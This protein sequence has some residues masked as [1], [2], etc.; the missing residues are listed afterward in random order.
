M[1]RKSYRKQLEHP[2]W[3]LKRL[4]VLKLFGA[5]CMRCGDTETMLHI[6]H[7]S[8]IPGLKPW[9]YDN[10]FYEVLCKNCH[11]DKHFPEPEVKKDLVPGYCTEVLPLIAELFRNYPYCNIFSRI[12]DQLIKRSEQ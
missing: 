2:K 1:S 4:E 11:R 6:H 3:Q 9:E 12:V 10:L 7:T 5:K 8:Y